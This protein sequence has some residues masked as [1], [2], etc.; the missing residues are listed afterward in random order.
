MF[1]FFRSK[2]Y[3]DENFLINDDGLH[4]MVER[5]AR[6]D[7]TAGS[8]TIYVTGFQAGGGVGM[9]IKYSGPDT[10]SK[11]IYMRMGVDP[12]E[13]PSGKYFAK[14]DPTGPMADETKFTMCVF[15]SEVW[16]N[17]I[18]SIRDADRGGNRLYFV[19]KAKVP[20]VDMHDL[21]SFRSY[22]PGTPDVNY[23]W[24]IYGQVKINK[25]GSYQF[26]IVSD[27]G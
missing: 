20:V 4:G 23:V 8:H 3:V 1:G 26:C 16:L 17:T 25:A 9:E 12:L 6:K 22:V 10:N 19:G 27:D 18:P 21:R 5:C 24:A 13:Q 15:R 14:C 2:M 11:M 7:L